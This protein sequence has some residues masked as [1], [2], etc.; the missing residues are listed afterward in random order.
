MM[1][2]YVLLLERVSQSFDRG[3]IVSCAVVGKPAGYYGLT[4]RFENEEKLNLA[5][6]EARV[7][8]FEMNNALTTVRSGFLS[9][10]P[11]TY[12][13]AQSLGLLADDSLET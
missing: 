7:S 2:K 4:K 3:I 6:S 8:D 9:F 10:A 1:T 13:Q 11:I 5:L 12:D